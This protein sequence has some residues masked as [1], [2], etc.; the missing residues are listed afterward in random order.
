MQKRKTEPPVKA[1]P[2]NDASRKYRIG[3]LRLTMLSLLILLW[4]G[5]VST[6]RIHHNN[7]DRLR[8]H[9][10]FKAAAKAAPDFVKEVGKTI[11]DLEY[12]LERK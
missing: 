7:L 8:N 5:C 1:N 4:T 6:P 9:P 12:E 10:Q 11:A 2:K 3:T